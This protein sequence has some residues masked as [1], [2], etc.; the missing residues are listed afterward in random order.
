MLRIEQDIAH[1]VFAAQPLD[2]QLLIQFHQRLCGDLLPDWAGR[3]RT[4]EVR[5][6]NL[7]PPPS[8]Q[9][10]VLM[11][12]YSADLAARWPTLLPPL[13]HLLLETLA[14]AEG[15]LLTVHP[16][17]D[18]NGRITRLWLREIL[19]RASLP[20]VDL[21]VEGESARR[22]YFAALEAADQFNWQ[23]LTDIWKTRFETAPIKS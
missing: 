17:P 23:P 9:V 8:H 21:T 5:V 22:A 15:R 2:E 13:G 16:F 4:N 14:F 1:G 20:A 11:R 3:W 10:P 18:F 19:R 7:Q 6:G 12:D